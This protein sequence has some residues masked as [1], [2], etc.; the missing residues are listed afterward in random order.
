[1][2]ERKEVVSLAEGAQLKLILIII[3][4]NPDSITKRA[5]VCDKSKLSIIDIKNFGKG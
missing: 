4:K 2:R 1:M 3:V 5:A